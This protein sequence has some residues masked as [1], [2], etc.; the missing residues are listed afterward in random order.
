MPPGDMWPHLQAFLVVTAGGRVQAE[1]GGAAQ[2][3]PST[4]EEAPAPQRGQGD[5]HTWQ[6][7]PHTTLSVRQPVE[8]KPRG[9]DH[10]L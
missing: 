10:G 7:T 2:G 1:A 4:E 9:R 3:G 8:V 5:R 6:P